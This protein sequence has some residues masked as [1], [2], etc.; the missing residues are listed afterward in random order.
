MVLGELHFIPTLTMPGRST[1][2]DNCRARAYFAF[3]M[4]GCVLFGHFSSNLSFLSSFSL[5]LGDGMIKTNNTV[6]KGL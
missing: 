1:N 4:G 5:S 6:L 2:L 3:R